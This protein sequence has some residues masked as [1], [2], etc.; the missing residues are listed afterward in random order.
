MHLPSCKSLQEDQSRVLFGLS[1]YGSTVDT[2]KKEESAHE[3][4]E[5][6]LEDH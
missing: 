3:V 2:P 1:D 6:Q 4:R 5:K